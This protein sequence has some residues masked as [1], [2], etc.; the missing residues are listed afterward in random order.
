MILR[1]TD[2]LAALSETCRRF[3]DVSS[4]D[5]SSR[6]LLDLKLRSPS[7]LLPL[8]QLSNPIL[9]KNIYIFLAKADDFLLLEKPTKNRA[10]KISL[11]LPPSSSINPHQTRHHHQGNPTK[12]AS[13]RIRRHD[14]H[15]TQPNRPLP[16]R[17]VSSSQSHERRARRVVV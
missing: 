12:Q 13:K 9:L 11:S 17:F 6:P 5:P 16:T 4:P 15:T 14:N 1:H 2:N 3:R 7:S 8:L 10:R